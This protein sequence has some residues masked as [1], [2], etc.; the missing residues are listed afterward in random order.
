[1]TAFFFDPRLL[2]TATLVTALSVSLMGCSDDK[3]TDSAGGDADAGES[4]IGNPVGDPIDIDHE[5][6]AQTAEDNLIRHLDGLE[7]TLAFLE[8]S[9]S[10]NNLV[11]MLFDD[12]D[13]D[14]DDD[15]GDDD[16]DDNDACA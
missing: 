8:E 16:D 5:T 7:D 13:D 10:M 15:D 6:A 12:D 11:G 14:D 2:R 1:M 9:S 3:D 4:A